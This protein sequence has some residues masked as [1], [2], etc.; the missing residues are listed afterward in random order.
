MRDCWLKL[1]GQ[2][3]ETNKEKKHQKRN[4]NKTKWKRWM[5]DSQFRKTQWIFCHIVFFHQEVSEPEAGSPDGSFFVVAEVIWN[6][7][8]RSQLEQIKWSARLWSQQKV[9]KHQ[10]KYETF[11]TLQYTTTSQSCNKTKWTTIMIQTR[12]PYAVL[13]TSLIWN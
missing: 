6:W 9:R 13:G 11:S 7:C 5:K 4:R 3:K 8:C 10:M 12:E 2:K 1:F